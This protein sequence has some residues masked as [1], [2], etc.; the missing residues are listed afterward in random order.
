MTACGSSSRW[1]TAV[2]RWSQPIAS[3]MPYVT[4]SVRRAPI[5][6]CPQKPS[7]PEVVSN[8]R[9]PAASPW[10]RSLAVAQSVSRASSAQVSSTS[11]MPSA[12]GKRTR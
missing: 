12:A 7:K 5:I 10:S 11:R 2:L 6:A 1:K 9:C 4:F 3:A 8:A